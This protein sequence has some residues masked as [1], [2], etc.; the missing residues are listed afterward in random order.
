MFFIIESYKSAAQLCVAGGVKYYTKQNY[1]DWMGTQ[2]FPEQKL[3]MQLASS[4]RISS[5][6][7]Y[8]SL[9]TSVTSL[10]SPGD[11][12]LGRKDEDESKLLH[13]EMKGNS[14]RS[15]ICEM[16]KLRNSSN[17]KSAHVT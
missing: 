14:K 15:E 7:N 11:C 9:V 17:D 6:A 3:F 8:P 16:A 4:E 2:L 12:C 1:R 13:K 10:T 5:M